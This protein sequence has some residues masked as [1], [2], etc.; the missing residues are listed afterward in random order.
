VRHSAAYFL[1]L[2]PDLLSDRAGFFADFL[3]ERLARFAAF[4]GERVF[5]AVFFFAAISLAPRTSAHVRCAK[6]FPSGGSD[7]GSRR[8]H[9]V[10]DYGS[11][12]AA[13]ESIQSC[14]TR[15]ARR[16]NDSATAPTARI[17]ASFGETRQDEFGL[18]GRF[19][20]DIFAIAI[21]AAL[22]G[23]LGMT[24]V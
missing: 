10:G 17:E 4:F 14:R 3:V 7:R 18:R 6:L 12:D 20:S 11:R 24:N 9:S 15:S 8:K 23:A 1:L 21:T 2:R 5:L 16:K 19:E 13:V 22:S